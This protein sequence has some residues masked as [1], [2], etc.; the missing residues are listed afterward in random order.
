MAR[1][2]TALFL[3]LIDYR[4]V[5]ANQNLDSYNFPVKGSR[6]LPTV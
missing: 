6:K 4:G 5:G 1:L 2:M 3:G